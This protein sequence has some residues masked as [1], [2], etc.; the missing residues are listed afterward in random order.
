MEITFFECNSPVI[1]VDKVVENGITVNGKLRE[2]SSILTPSFNIES[3]VI[4]SFNYCYI[5]QFNRYYYITDITSVNSKIVRIECKVDVLKSFSTDIKNS[6][7]KTK[8]A[9][10]NNGYYEKTEI[11][12]EVRKD[13]EKVDFPNKPFDEN[14]SII[15]V[16]INGTGV[17]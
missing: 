16:A 1:M 11:G 17:V 8:Q 10:K 5:P 7:G 13:T 4:P 9:I 6:L 14:G 15:L 12:V 3:D 2:N